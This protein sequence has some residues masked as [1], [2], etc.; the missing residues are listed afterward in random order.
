MGSK[1]ADLAPLSRPMMFFVVKARELSYTFL[2]LLP[3][4]KNTYGLVARSS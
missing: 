2:I 1:L 3:T 4:V